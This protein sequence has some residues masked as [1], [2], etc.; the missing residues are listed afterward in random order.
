[1]ADYKK[2]YA[3]LVY[4]TSKAID[5]L[6]DVLHKCEDMYIEVPESE[7][8]VVDSSVFKENKGEKSTV[9]NE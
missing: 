9:V 8:T 6:Q 7:L 1:M 2:M 4:E 3:D 5:I